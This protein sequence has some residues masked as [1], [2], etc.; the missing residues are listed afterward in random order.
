MLALLTSLSTH[1]DEMTTYFGRS[2]NQMVRNGWKKTVEDGYTTYTMANGDD[3][4]VRAMKTNSSAYIKED[5]D[6]QRKRMEYMA[7]D[8]EGKLVYRTSCVSNSQRRTGSCTDGKTADGKDKWVDCPDEGRNELSCV[9]V[10]EPY[11]REMNRYTSWFSSNQIASESEIKK[12]ADIFTKLSSRLPA[13]VHLNNY[14]KTGVSR[15]KEHFKSGQEQFPDEK[16]PLLTDK[17]YRGIKYLV[18]AMDACEASK[19]QWSDKSFSKP[20]ESVLQAEDE[21]PADGKK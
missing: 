10:S 8:K 21:W 15:L 2:N 11:C 6:L 20:T 19:D 13:Y 4:R 16:N 5:V 7:L 1:A 9:T 18:R 12:C 14:H 3:I 17:G